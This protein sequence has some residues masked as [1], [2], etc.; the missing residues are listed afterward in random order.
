RCRAVLQEIVQCFRRHGDDKICY[1]G[2]LGM[3]G[4]AEKSMLSDGV[5]PDPDGYRL[6][7]R[8]YAELAWPR[9]AALAGD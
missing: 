4:A 8:R 6:M 3:L 9:L 2:D 1:G 7:S 5:H